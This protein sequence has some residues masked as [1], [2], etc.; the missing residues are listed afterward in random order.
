MK[1][2][3]FPLHPL[4]PRPTLTICSPRSKP[5]IAYGSE[6]AGEDRNECVR[7]KDTTASHFV[8]HCGNDTSNPQSIIGNTSIGDNQNDNGMTVARYATARVGGRLNEGL[9]ALTRI[10]D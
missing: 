7:T 8:R 6:L 2:T 5:L 9:H 4:P 1:R 3:A 10:G